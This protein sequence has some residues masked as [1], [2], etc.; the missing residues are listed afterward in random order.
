MNGEVR[1]TPD[2]LILFHVGPIPVNA[3]IVFTWLTML[4]LIVVALMVRRRLTSEVEISPAQNMLEIIVGGM[5]DQIRELAGEGPDQFLPFVGTLFLFIATCNLLAVVPGYQAPTSSLSTTFALALCVFVSVPIYGISKRGLL[6]YLGQY[7]RPTPV[8]LP[9]HVIGEVSR[10][11]ALA[12]RL[13]GNVMAGALIAA[14]L[15]KIAPIVLPTVMQAL[16]LLTG[17][18]QAYIFAVLA[19]VYIASATR[20]SRGASSPEEA[21]EHGAREH[22]GEG[23]ASEQKGR[24]DG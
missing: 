3:T 14:I 6:G 16:S 9:F 2:E 1:L 7:V 11:I 13:F 23:Q 4:L 10:T 8:M 24:T 15:L 12:I 5:R 20:A 21:E 17:L 18:V 22:Q 19:M